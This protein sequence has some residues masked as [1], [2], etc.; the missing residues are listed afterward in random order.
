MAPP[1]H[2]TNGAAVG[3]KTPA[4]EAGT[5]PLLFILLLLL[6]SP[7]LYDLLVAVEILMADAN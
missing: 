5:W 3:E 1:Q 2:D 6:L 7:L 4:T